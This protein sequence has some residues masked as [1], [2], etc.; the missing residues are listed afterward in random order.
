VSKLDKLTGFK[1]RVMLDE[2]LTHTIRFYA[3]R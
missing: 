1:A 2:G 3:N